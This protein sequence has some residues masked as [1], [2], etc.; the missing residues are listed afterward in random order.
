VHL[1]PEAKVEALVGLFDNGAS[2]RAAAR[3]AGVA[4]E[5]AARYR[6]IWRGL[7]GARIVDTLVI[8]LPPAA[9]PGARRRGRAPRPHPGGPGGAVPGVARRGGLLVGRAG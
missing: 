5:T 7:R 9:R 8:R 3:G 4:R 2:D 6:A 1:V